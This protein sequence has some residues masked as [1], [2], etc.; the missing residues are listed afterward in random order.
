MKGKIMRT[1]EIEKN[2]KT[3]KNSIK[4]EW[5]ELTED[6]LNKMEGNWDKMVD[7]LAL[8]YS[9]TKMEAEDQLNKWKIK[10]KDK[11]N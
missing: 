10:V 2:W 1:S 9:L 4:N 11:L 6:E 8:K 3:L 7:T 5:N